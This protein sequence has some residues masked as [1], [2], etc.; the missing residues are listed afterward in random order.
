MK[1]LKI[2]QSSEASSLEHAVNE[3]LSEHKHITVIS[4]ELKVIEG[5]KDSFLFYI[6]YT[7]SLMEEEGKLQTLAVVDQSEVSAETN[8]VVEV[9][10]PQ[11]ALLKN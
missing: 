4:C 9:I 5:A 8:K 3:W 1:T 7:N 11:D 2:I 10:T 6:L